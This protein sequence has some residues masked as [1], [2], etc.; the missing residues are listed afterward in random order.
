MTNNSLIDKYTF[1]GSVA[2]GSHVMSNA[3][4]RIS[5]VTLELGGK[6]AII[7]FDDVDIDQ[8]VEWVMFG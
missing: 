4:K 5:N 2:S 3:A 6:S 8:A 1:T 7:V